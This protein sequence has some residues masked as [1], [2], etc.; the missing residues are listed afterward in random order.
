MSGQAAAIQKEVRAEK[1]ADVIGAILDAD[2][3]LT[4]RDIELETMRSSRQV[5]RIL[6]DLVDRDCVRRVQDAEDGRVYR[7][8]IVVGGD[9]T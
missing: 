2:E 4:R 8:E 7:Y 6:T 3:P 5:R 1:Y 9:E